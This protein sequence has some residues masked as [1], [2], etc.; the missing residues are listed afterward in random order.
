MNN[1]IQGIRALL[2]FCYL[3]FSSGFLLAQ[4]EEATDTVS[5]KL[6][7]VGDI[8]GHDSQIESAKIVKDSMY[9]YTPCFEWVRPVIQAA[10]LAIGNLE[11][12]LPGKPPYKGYPQFRSPD[13]LALAL[14]HAGFDVLVTSNNH[15]N[16]AGKMGV[17]NTILT[18]DD[19]FFYHTGTFQNQDIRDAYYP[20][21]V[22]KGAFKLAFLNYTYGTNGLPTVAPTIVNEIDEVQIEADM[23]EAQALNPDAIIV[24]M[25][26]GQ[27]YQLNENSEQRELAQKIFEWGADLVIGAHPHVIQPVK[28]RKLVKDSTKTGLVAYSLGNFISGQQKANTDGGLMLEVTLKKAISTASTF[29]GEHHFIPV[30]RYIE[31]GEDKKSTYRLI[32]ISAFEENPAYQAKIPVKDWEAMTSFAKRMRTHLGKHDSSERKLSLPGLFPEIAN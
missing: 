31:K 13:D 28:T 3:F 17:I 4:S 15:S 16:D 6:L 19:Y 25:H 10:D 1:P 2:L 8:M 20:L 9:D 32:P 14:R 30:W 26:W 27:E 12:T 22:Y 18:L 23:K 11:L 21:I 7:F 5:L 29:L 24:V